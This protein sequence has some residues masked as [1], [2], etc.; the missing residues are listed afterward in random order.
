LASEIERRKMIGS[1]E[2]IKNE[3]RSRRNGK[4]SKSGS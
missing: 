3:N 1:L 4:R 2:D